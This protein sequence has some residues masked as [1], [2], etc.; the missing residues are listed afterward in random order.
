[1]APQPYRPCYHPGCEKPATRRVQLV[2][3]GGRA[4]KG[5]AVVMVWVCQTHRMQANRNLA[6]GLPTFNYKQGSNAWP[7][8]R[9]KK[10]LELDAE[11]LSCREI[12]RKLDAHFTTVARK[13]KEHRK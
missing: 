7:E 9:I 1:M 13:L 11:G 5:G 2:E 8:E 3:E 10:L 12:A 4:P 6:K